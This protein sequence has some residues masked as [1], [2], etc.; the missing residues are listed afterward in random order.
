MPK[1]RIDRL[2]DRDIHK[3]YH[4]ARKVLACNLIHYRKVNNVS[5]GA[6]AYALGTSSSHI[7]R[8]ECNLNVDFDF[9]SLCRLARY[10]EIT[11]CDLLIKHADVDYSKFERHAEQSA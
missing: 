10:F 7:V 11:V 9:F 2:T 3:V 4:A 1:E 5:Q 8:I 6:L